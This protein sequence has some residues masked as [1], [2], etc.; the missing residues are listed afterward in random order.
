MN[1]AWWTIVGFSVLSWASLS[2]GSRINGG[3]LS[4]PIN[5]A[6]GSLSVAFA[7]IAGRAAMFTWIYDAVGWVA[8]IHPVVGLVL[9][10]AVILAI[11]FTVLVL[12]WDRWSAVSASLPIVAA[13]LVVPS[14]LA[15]GMP[16]GEFG[17]TAATA[18]V[19]AADWLLAN[20]GGWF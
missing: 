9:T 13:W 4:A 14:L 19:T 12:T 3:A 16:P 8:A 11:F 20:I 6:T 17:A 18:V 2:L 1:P 5:W 15:H 7:L 10:A